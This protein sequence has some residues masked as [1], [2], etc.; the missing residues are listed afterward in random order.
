MRMAWS[1]GVLMVAVLAGCI[2]DEETGFVQIKAVPTLA[3]APL[4]LY[5]NDAKLETLKN[6]EALLTHRTGTSKLQVEAGTGQLSPLCEIIVGKN[7][8]T[9]VTISTVLR[10]PRCQCSHTAGQGPQANRTC[11]S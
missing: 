7:R 6:G 8:I 10:P 11:V 9:T 4:A 1:A 2:R 3:G 5:L